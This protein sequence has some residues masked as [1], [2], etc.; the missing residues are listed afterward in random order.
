MSV[1]VETPSELLRKATNCSDVLGRNAARNNDL[2]P[3]RVH[4]IQLSRGSSSCNEALRFVVQANP[5]GLIGRDAKIHAYCGSMTSTLE[6]TNPLMREQ[7]VLYYWE[8]E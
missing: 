8:C 5:N 4:S 2:K 3:E 6:L 7:E 1:R